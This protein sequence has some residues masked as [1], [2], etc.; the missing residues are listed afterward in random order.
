M[1]RNLVIKFIFIYF[2]LIFI[3]TIIFIY[4]YNENKENYLNQKTKQ[5]LLE[6]KAIYNKHKVI[7]QLIF[8]TDINTPPKIIDLYKNAYKATDLE[9]NIIREKLLKILESKYNKLKNYNLKQ[10]HFHLPDNRSFLRMHRPKK[11][12]DDLTNVRETV[13]YVNEHKKYFHGFEEG[14]I[15]NGFRF[16]YPLFTNNNEHIGSVEICIGFNSINSPNL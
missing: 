7:S 12:G 13:K 11:F 5:H 15:F 10:L 4:D 3:L 16:V 2:I 8:D 1:Y 6:Y 9:K 14:R